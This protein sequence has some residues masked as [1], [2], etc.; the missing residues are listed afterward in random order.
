LVCIPAFLAI[1]GCNKAADPPAA[2]KPDYEAMAVALDAADEE[3]ATRA[4]LTAS[5]TDEQILRAIG[6]EP[7]TLKLK[8]V[9]EGWGG[10]SVIHTAYTSDVV[11]IEISRSADTGGLLVYG[12]QGTWLVKGKR[13]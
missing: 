8:P 13:P 9:P 10:P 5:M 7:A 2:A 1:G 11:D 4:H 12:T 3:R 6:V